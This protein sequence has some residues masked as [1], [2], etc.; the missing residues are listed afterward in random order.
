MNQSQEFQHLLK[1][2]G[3]KSLEK[4]KESKKECIHTLRKLAQNQ[5]TEPVVIEFY[6]LA[7]LRYSTLQ[8]AQNN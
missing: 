3:D 7:Q 8:T 2:L 6:Q 5:E 1:N 4:V